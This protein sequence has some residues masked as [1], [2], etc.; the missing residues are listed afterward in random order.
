MA[1]WRGYYC[2]V[3]QDAQVAQRQ[4]G[5]PVATGNQDY[6]AL[7]LVLERCSVSGGRMAFRICTTDLEG[8]G[9]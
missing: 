5:W 2:S 6:T 4:H 3:W 8:S 1:T 7:K 9:C